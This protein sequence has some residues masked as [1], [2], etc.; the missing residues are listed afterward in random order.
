MTS[1]HK[2]V[3][4]RGSHVDEVAIGA[5]GNEGTIKRLVTHGIGSDVLL[6]TFRLDPGQ[7]GRFELPHPLGMQQ[8]IYYLLA[9]RLSVT[10][11]GEEFI[12][13]AG[14]AILFPAGNTYDIT[15]VGDTAVELVWTGYPAPR[16]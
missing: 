11:G 10:A 13:E 1:S 7:R 15:T 8:E 6:G 14:D 4:V 12:A 9:G 3:R 2:P 5:N 16:N